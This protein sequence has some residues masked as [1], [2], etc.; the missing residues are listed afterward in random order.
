MVIGILGYGTVGKSVYKLAL[1]NNIK[2]KTILVRN[3]SG[4]KL[5]T[6]DIDKIINDKD[7]DTIV[8]CTSSNKLAYEY[9]IKGLKHHKNIVTSNKKMLVNYFKEINEA[10]LN[11]GSSLLYSSACGGGI[12]FLQELKKIKVVDKIMRLESINNGTCNYILDKMFSD[13]LEFDEA[14]NKAQLNGYA[15][16]D[17]SDDIEGFDSANKLILASFMAFNKLYKLDAIFI[18]GIANINKKDIDFFKEKGKKCILLAKAYKEQLTVIPTLVSKGPF[19]E[20]ALNNNCFMIE[21]E[22]LGKTFFIGQGAGGLPTASNILRDLKDINNS[23]ADK[24]TCYL[25]PS[26]NLIK[27]RYYIRSKNNDILITDPITIKELKEI[28]KDDD[29]LCEVNND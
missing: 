18:K 21:S 24:V 26:D 27:N 5:E 14:L 4:H 16:R 8:E 17:P 7:I 29:F 11:S 9:C 19:N 12:P 25:K 13:N 20:I 28:I 15:E 2:V 22:D 6:D 1:K 10:A 3:K 23:F